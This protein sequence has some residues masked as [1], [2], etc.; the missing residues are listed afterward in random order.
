MIYL[1]QYFSLFDSFGT[2]IQLR[3][4]K[5]QTQQKTIIGGITTI[6]VY[7]LSFCYFIYIMVLWQIGDIGPQ[8]S[9]FNAVQNF[10]IYQTGDQSLLDLTF[11]QFQQ[12][13]DPFDEKNI[14]LLPLLIYEIQ[15]KQQVPINMLKNTKVSQFNSTQ[16]QTKN[17]TLILSNNS[18]GYK[19]Q[20][21]TIVI[22]DCEDKYLLQNQSCAKQELV[23]KFK[24]LADS[25]MYYN[26]IQTYN[27]KL[28][29][30]QTVQRKQYLSFEYTSS[31]NLYMQL[32]T[33]NLN[34]EDGLLFQNLNSFKY[35]DD[36]S[37]MNQVNSKEYNIKSLGYNYYFCFVL[38]LSP[39][40]YEV[41]IRYQNLGQIFAMVGS[42]ASVLMS[43]GIL[44]EFL[45]GYYQD[46][47]LIYKILQQYFP[48]K[49]Q[50]NEIG[51]II[52]ISGLQDNSQI[53]KLQELADSK[54]NI[55]NI[56]Y[57]ISRIEL[58]LIYK[59]GQNELLSANN[60]IIQTNQFEESQEMTSL[61][62]K[63]FYIEDMD[64]FQNQGI[65]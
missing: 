12:H 52:N 42:I 30:I 3:G 32:N 47:I 16:I 15:G 38:K 46:N 17:L 20:D 49:I 4:Y 54:L 28:K 60:F 8:V 29:Q 50:I 35:V 27:T 44:I 10:S 33:A 41:D 58:F 39:L 9:K 64:V 14:I 55:L 5:G 25:I 53:Q 11:T 19:Q 63:K 26:T 13:L 18:D 56:I 45:N 2:S 31:Y 48:N 62:T 23:D 36:I 51:Q 65:Q 43:V 61:D 6:T 34:V 24:S 21:A 22:V 7:T 57:Q 40:V 1:M 59:F 37:F